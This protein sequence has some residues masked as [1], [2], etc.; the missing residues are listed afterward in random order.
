MDSHRDETFHTNEELLLTRKDKTDI[1]ERIDNFKTEL[2]HII[3]KA[4]LIVTV[5]QCLAIA[6]SVWVM[7]HCMNH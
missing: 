1:I 6:G 5:I 7:L 3:Y 2:K 4:Y